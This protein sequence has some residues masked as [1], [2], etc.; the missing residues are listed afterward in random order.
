[1]IHFQ[2]LIY[3][4][5]LS[6]GNTPIIISLDRHKLTN[7]S[8][9]SGSGKSTILDAISFVLYGKP[10]RDINKGQLAN[11]LNGK[12]SEVSIKFAKNDSQFMIQRSLNDLKIYKNGQ[13]LP[14]TSIKADQEVLEDILGCSHF[15]FCKTILLGTANFTSFMSLKP[16][17]K[18]AFIEE[19]LNLDT[20]SKMCQVIK[21]IKKDVIE[22][23]KEKDG[24]LKE[25]MAKKTTLEQ[26]LA[27][28]KK[29]QEDSIKLQK[30]ANEN[31]LKDLQN[32]KTSLYNQMEMCKRM[33][34]GIN[35]DIDISYKKVEVLTEN[36]KVLLKE[37]DNLK[38]LDKDIELRKHSEY[39]PT[40]NR[41]LDESDLEKNR[42]IIKE[43]ESLKEKALEKVEEYEKVKKELI[44]ESEH[45]TNSV[46]GK[47]NAE[48]ENNILYSEYCV[49][50]AELE[51]V[52]QTLNRLENYSSKA[53]LETEEK[54][55]VI[56]QNI[57]IIQQQIETK[58]SILE[59]IE[60][61][62]VALGDTGIKSHI[63][64]NYI[65]EFNYLVNH[66]L[67]EMD[68]YVTFT[69]DSTFTETFSESRHNKFTYDNYSSGEKQRIDL[70]ILFALKQLTFVNHTFRTNLLILDEILDSYLDNEA[71]ENVI[72]LLKSEQ[73]KNQNIIIISHKD[74]SVYTD[75]T[76]SFKKSDFTVVS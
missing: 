20:F 25:E 32:K 34:E 50:L 15:L 17:E 19:L 67:R 48:N 74:V 70:A 30:D 11:T 49:I 12:T 33:I 53:V 68:F 22:S 37:L 51:K 38:F 71:T 31:V 7:F 63:I 26:T 47:I 23:L 54:I 73:F 28:I 43:L 5:F 14:Q 55:S 56:E 39:C 2:E 6:A 44:K 8:G 61:G 72:R 58:K 60:T 35:S 27:T 62:I 10:F 4:N 16:S 13:M 3:K 69:M 29:E 24:K 65:P 18:R 45:Y 9:K 42:V 41:K 40:C 57:T 76:I 36:K 21:D 1:M 64:D 66:F 75:N 46:R 59:S 52:L